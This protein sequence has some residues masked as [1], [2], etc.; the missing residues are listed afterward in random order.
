MK[1]VI[2]NI[3]FGYRNRGVS[4]SSVRPARMRDAF[5]KAGYDILDVDGH[6]RERAA[7]VDRLISDLSSLDPSKTLLYAES[8]TFPHCFDLPSRLPGPSPD[9][10][11][12][13]AAKAHGIP[14]GLFYRDM[15]WRYLRHQ[16]WRARCIQGMLRPFFERE[17]RS[18]ASCYDVLFG[19]TEQFLAAI[20]EAKNARRV[21]L[22]PGM[23]EGGGIRKPGSA[24]RLIHVGGMTDHHGLYDMLPVVRGI[25]GTPWSLDMVCRQPEWVR[26]RDH[27]E[28]LG[29][30]CSILHEQGEGKSKHM[31]KATVGLLV[32]GAHA[33]RE[34]A[35]PV[36]LLEYLAHGLPILVSAPSESARFVLKHG[37]GWAVAPE[38]EAV[39]EMLQQLAEHPEDIQAAQSRIP[40]ALKHQTWAHRV[41]QVEKALW[42]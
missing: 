20:P 31:A 32:Y 10:K 37:V 9:I 7:V 2:F 18:Y 22:P 11:L 16:G 25:Q 21:A 5:A 19:P 3:Q 12:A 40:A 13:K 6:R 23:Q 17:I 24:L 8:A 28:P 36:K 1:T 39:R 35:F 26:F 30:R 29:K 41:N 34:L 27:Y 38:P 33:Y 4:G 42:R 15:H 14:V